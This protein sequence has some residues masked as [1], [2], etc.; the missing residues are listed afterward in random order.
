MD[1]EP[2][3]LLQARRPSNC[4]LALFPVAPW[5]ISGFSRLKEPMTIDV[6]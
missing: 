1:S 2:F 5:A 6:V 4:C 3:G